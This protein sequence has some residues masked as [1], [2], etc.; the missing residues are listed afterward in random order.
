MRLRARDRRTGRLNSEL[1][2]QQADLQGD[3]SE[4]EMQT[5]RPYGIHH[6]LIGRIYCGT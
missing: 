3:S 5:H 1:P 2:Q 6:L 4:D